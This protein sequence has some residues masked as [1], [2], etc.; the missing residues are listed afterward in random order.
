MPGFRGPGSRAG[1][2]EPSLGTG[3]ILPGLIRR[4]EASGYTRLQGEAAG[5]ADQGLPAVRDGPHRSASCPT[6]TRVCAGR[7]HALRMCS[8][9]PRMCAFPSTAVLP[10]PWMGTEPRLGPV[11]P[12]SARDTPLLPGTA[13]LC[14]TWAGPR[15]PEFSQTP[16]QLCT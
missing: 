14:V 16:V 2:R 8:R 9:T 10:L 13:S 5:H 1:R 3:R 12:A 7:E 11:C 6:D 4:A 15:C